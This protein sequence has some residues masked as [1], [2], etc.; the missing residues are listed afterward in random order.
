MASFRTAPRELA[1]ISSRPLRHNGASRG[2]L[3]E[4]AIAASAQLK[5][6]LIGKPGFR[7]QQRASAAQNFTMPAMSPTM[8]EGNI[9]K[10]KVKEGKY[11]PFAL[12]V[13]ETADVSFRRG[14]LF[15]TGDVLLEIETDKAQMDV[16]AQDD[17]RMARI[18][19]RTF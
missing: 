10:W 4:M 7:S 1:R 5:P 6:Q 2:K 13:D 19:V 18:T 12:A 14:E 15:T 16:E 17:G 11:L 3:N 8:T 9:A